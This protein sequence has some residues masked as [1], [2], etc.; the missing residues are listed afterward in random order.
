LNVPGIGA[1][2]VDGNGRTVYELSSGTQKNLACTAST[3]CTSVWTPL[4]FPRGTASA[5]A[6]GGA[7]SSLL[8]TTTH[9]GATFPTYNG[10]V[11]YEFTGDTGSG[12]AN[13]QNI[14][15][16]GGTWH[17]LDGSGTPV[18]AATSTTPSTTYQY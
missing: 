13:G 8:S 11:L 3:G 7:Q 12:Q 16:F 14:S 9:G 2:L 6:S 1:V 15:S 4:V 17:V 18:A 5:T 10:W